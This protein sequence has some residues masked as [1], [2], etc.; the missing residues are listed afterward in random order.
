M[1]ETEKRVPI[2]D[3]RKKNAGQA[4]MDAMDENKSMLVLFGVIVA[5]LAVILIS[6]LVLKV[7]AVPVCV[8]VVIEAALAVC[9]HDVPI[10]LHGLVVI[11]QVIAGILTGRTVLMLLCIAIY[12]IG[13][14]ALRFIRE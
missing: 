2:K 8:M 9:L 6:I 12:L 10:W 5:A 1:G 4:V 7:S 3:R 14:L 11:A 13:I